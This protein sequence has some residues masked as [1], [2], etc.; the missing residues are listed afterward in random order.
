MRLQMMIKKWEGGIM[1]II[2]DK[3]FKN[4]VVIFFDY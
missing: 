2:F 3:I 1:K 4:S